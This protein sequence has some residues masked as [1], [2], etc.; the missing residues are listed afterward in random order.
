MH[1]NRITWLKKWLLHKEGRGKKSAWYT[2]SKRKV[3]PTHVNL[4]GGCLYV[5]EEEKTEFYAKY[6]KHALVNHKE[7][8]L[9]EQPRVCEDGCS[10]SPV[11][12][13]IDLRYAAEG[14]T[15]ELCELENAI[16]DWSV[17]MFRHLDIE[18]N[19]TDL[20]V[21]V[22]TCAEFPLKQERQVQQDDG[23]VVKKTIFKDGLHIYFPNVVA[24]RRKL[25]EIRNEAY[26]AMGNRFS[27]TSNDSDSK[28]DECIYKKNGILL[29]G[30]SKRERYR[31]P[32]VLTSCWSLT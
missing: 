14:L 27:N 1:L 7:I 10:Y 26:E 25:L 6:L 3:K 12:I 24:D 22:T 5:P 32:Y 17:S 31:T 18:T 8:N 9:T 23:S 16:K 28:I 13:D 21:W 2:E 15:W 29:V 11:I 4:G 19:A 30:S 20:D